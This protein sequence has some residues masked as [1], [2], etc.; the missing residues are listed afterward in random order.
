ME[1]PGQICFS[2]LETRLMK[3]WEA[4]CSGF[5][6][7]CTYLWQ[8]IF[9][10]LNSIIGLGLFNPSGPTLLLFYYYT[11]VASKFVKGDSFVILR[12][13]HNNNSRRT[14]I[15]HAAIKYIHKIDVTFCTFVTKELCSAIYV[16]L[17]TFSDMSHQ[18]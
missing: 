1:T 6:Y 18:T 12:K 2:D 17:L 14:L 13:S 11:I 5:P 7:T 9:T 8:E 15:I 10:L 3:N 4:F 16:Q